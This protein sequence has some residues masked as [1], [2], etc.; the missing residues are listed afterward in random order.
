MAPPR[1]L[2]TTEGPSRPSL[3]LLPREEKGMRTTRTEKLDA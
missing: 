1:A 2:T 3:S